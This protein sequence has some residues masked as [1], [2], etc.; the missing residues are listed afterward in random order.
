MMAMKKSWLKFGLLAV[1]LVVVAVLAV[2]FAR[3]LFDFLSNEQQ[4]E[5]WL[6]RLGPLGP[7]GVIALNALQVVV[8]FIPG[9]AMSVA[10]GFLYGFP[11]GA[12]YGAIGMAIGGLIAI[13]L[14]RTFGRPLVV[15]MV[16][17]KRMQRWEDVAHLN[18]LPI[19]FILMLGPFGD[20]PY[21]IAGLTTLAIWK[22]IAVA[23][24]LRTP[25][26]FVAAA[27]G[28]GLVD[29]RS[30]WV[31]GGAILVM[32]GAVVAMRYQSRIESFV[33]QRVLPR[34]VALGKQSKPSHSGADAPLEVADYDAAAH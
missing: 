30:P 21:Y 18:S 33:D 29:W 4:L 23:L 8:A 9:Y 25:S 17:E 24:L 6:D 32:T 26:I 3:P 5:A 15:R 19:W 12:V 10:S 20:V 14:A 28:A 34:V 16:G 27:I 22:I 7:L 11:L 2:R 31:I 13:L 1:A